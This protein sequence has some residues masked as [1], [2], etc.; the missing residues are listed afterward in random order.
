MDLS[1]AG[2]WRGEG[3]DQ[4]AYQRGLPPMAHLCGGDSVGAEFGPTAVLPLVGDEHGCAL[5]C[6]LP[7]LVQ[8]GARGGRH[9]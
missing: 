4:E 3:W 1:S 7:Q 9:M 2:V 6:Q 5:A 8:V